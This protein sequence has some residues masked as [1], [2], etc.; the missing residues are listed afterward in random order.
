MMVR[1]GP[2]VPYLEVEENADKTTELC[3]ESRIDLTI[4]LRGLLNN[5]QH[6]HKERVVEG[7]GESWVGE[8]SEC[9][10]F[11]EL[12]QAPDV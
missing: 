12:Q 2:Y 9:T 10:S 8:V 3:V 4:R 1:N 7:G 5:Q 6:I 11:D